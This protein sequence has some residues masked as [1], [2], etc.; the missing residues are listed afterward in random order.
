MS[1]RS[2]TCDGLLPCNDKEIQSMKG[3]L[4]LFIN[5]KRIKWEDKRFC[6]HNRV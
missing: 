4:E 6:L 5:F 1:G 2:S 3:E